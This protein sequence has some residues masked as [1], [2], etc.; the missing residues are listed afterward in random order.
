MER[1]LW[2]KDIFSFQLRSIKN[3]YI[4]GIPICMGFILTILQ[5]SIGQFFLRFNSN[6]SDVGILNLCFSIASILTIIN[7]GFLNY[8]NPTSFEKYENNKNNIKY[9]EIMGQN[10]IFFSLTISFLVLIFK[11]IVLLLFGMSYR[12]ATYV[13]AFV[14]FIPLFSLLTQITGRGIQ[15]KKK[16]YWSFI[17]MIISL[18]IN[19]I[20]CY[21]FIPLFG[22]RGAAIS[23]GIA[24]LA[25]F[26]IQSIIS[27]YL[28]HINYHFEK[29]IISLFIL[30]SVFFF[31]TF[32]SNIG[33]SFFI[34]TIALFSIFILYYD[35]LKKVLDILNY[36]MNRQEKNSV[37]NK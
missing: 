37:L 9:F 7:T 11:D 14:L 20:G 5:K 23:I 34:N 32:S 36:I 17:A 24:S 4:Y 31:N 12:E 16:T 22:A 27:I 35:Q 15:F 18:I 21:F 10:V 6:F 19:V 3:N 13:L 29:L 33:L 28:Y 25:N 30:N 2:L 8:W 1:K 26:I